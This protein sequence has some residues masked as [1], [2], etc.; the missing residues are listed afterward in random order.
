MFI[1]TSLGIALVGLLLA[2]ASCAPAVPA[3]E[4][5]AP[6][7][8]TYAEPATGL[9]FDYPSSWGEVR[10]SREL[11]A[12]DTGKRLSFGF[13]ENDRVH[14]HA[15]SAD[16]SEG[17]GEGAPTYFTVQPAGGDPATAA[18]AARFLR[19][20]FDMLTWERLADGHY[21]MVHNGGLG[22]DALVVSHLRT[23]W[24]APA[25]FSTLMVNARVGD[26][27]VSDGAAPATAYTAADAARVIGQPASAALLAAVDALVAS[28]R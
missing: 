13:T 15:V 17:I 7:L 4:A 6:T 11:P 10:V 2:G 9:A 20:E 19:Q 16:Y 3:P 14:L 26:F 22:G 28:I 27:R 21:R 23:S 5:P 18:D 8:T 24:K 1:R 12:M 25:G